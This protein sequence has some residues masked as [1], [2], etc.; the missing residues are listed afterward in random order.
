MPLP[1]PS[2]ELPLLLARFFPRDAMLAQVLTSYGPLS[3]CLSVCLYNKSHVLHTYLPERSETVLLSAYIAGT[4]I[5]LSLPKLV[6]LT[7]DILNQSSLQRLLSI[8]D[9]I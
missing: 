4:V 7:I 9:F 8:I 1:G 2:V 6:T 3:V 5:N